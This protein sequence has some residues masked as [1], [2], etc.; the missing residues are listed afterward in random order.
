MK[1]Y[2]TS[3]P[4]DMILCNGKIISCN[5]NSNVYQ[6]LAI[7]SGLIA[8]VGANEA[9][10]ALKGAKTQLVDLQGRAVIPGL[11]DTHVHTSMAALSELKGELFIPRSVKELLE[12]IRYKTSII[13]TGEWLYFRNTYPTRLEEYRFPTL[14]EL[15]S[16]APVNPV[17]LDGFYAGQ[18]NS[19][20]LNAAGITNSSRP[21]RGKLCRDESGKL[22]GTLFMCGDLI[23]KYIPKPEYSQKDYIDA[24]STLHSNYSELGITSVI[25]GGTSLTDIE[26]INTMNREGHQNV[27]TVYT[28]IP[29]TPEAVDKSVSEYRS[30]VN[31][32]AEWGKLGFLKVVL[33][34]GI[35]TGTSYMR[36]PYGKGCSVFGIDDPEFRGVISYDKEQLTNLSR[37][38]YEHELQMTAH[39][40]GDAATDVLLSAYIALNESMPVKGRRFSIIHG[41]FTDLQTLQEIKSLG[42]V[43]ISQPA[44]HYKDGSILSRVLDGETMQTF[45]PYRSI[46]ELGVHAAAGSDHMVKHDSVLAVNPY[47]P[48]I[49]MYNLVTRRTC[50]GDTV[51]PEQSIT[52][53][54]ALKLYTLNGAYA[55]FDENIK[56]SLE[57]GKLA[58]LAVLSSDYLTCSEEE[59]PKIKSL[60]TVVGGKT[61][62]GGI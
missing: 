5:S 34:G 16:A 61:V 1:T 42:V 59:I 32:P 13:E 51:M 24:I 55:S 12:F 15:D 11:I 54:K 62:Y 26:A 7:K 58:D 43:L 41:D 6:A 33:D 21:I 46:D 28:L 49:G 40:I 44:W 39:S 8:A 56:G 37:K 36:K 23:K 29:K 25:D 10:L 17:Y 31:T 22:T 57:V 2:L 60:M 47:N 52:R 20:A 48:F 45:L 9:V 18:A 19:C 3:E 30:A 38:A 27:R 14:E 4:A 53:E 35:L 50:K